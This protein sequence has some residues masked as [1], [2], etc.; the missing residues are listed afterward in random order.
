MKGLHTYDTSVIISRGLSD[1]PDGADRFLFSSVV[2]LELSASAKDDAQRKQI[3]R[4]FREY[5]KDNSLIYPDLND[6]QLASKILYWLTNKRRKEQG[7]KLAKL[8][9][10]VSQRMAMDVLLAVSS[11]RWEATIVVDNWVDF[12]AIQH[13]C[14]GLKIQR[15]TD[16]FGG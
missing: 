10:G 13:Y 4:L 6:W 15:A 1:F 16:F 5:A 2:L 11:K 7:G 3:D 12:K 8:V 9:P 14:K